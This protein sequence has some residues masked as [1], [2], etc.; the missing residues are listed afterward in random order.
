MEFDLEAPRL[1]DENDLLLLDAEPF[2]PMAP[3]PS[4]RA[5]PL[6]STSESSEIAEA[7]LQRRH[8]ATKQL[9]VD[10]RQEL[11]NSDLAQWKDA[12]AQ[13]M[14]EASGIK[15][16]HK[17]PFIAKKNAAF[18]VM[19][20][21]IGSVG[22]GLGSS[23]MKSPL[24]MF[25][26]NNIMEALTGIQVSTA[27]RKRDR[28]EEDDNESDSEARRLR[29]RKDDG[30]HIGRG[31]DL[32]LNDDDTAMIPGSEVSVNKSIHP[33]LSYVFQGI[34][35]GRHAQITLEDP[36]FPWNVS[37][38]AIG[39][40]QG[41][42]ARGRGFTGSVGGF[43]TSAAGASSLPGMGGMQPSSL[44]RRASRITSA[45][46]L[47]GRSRERYSSLELPT[48]EDDDEL[49]GGQIITDDQALDNFQLYGPAA[50]VDT[51]TAAQSQWVKATLD[52]EAN[53]FLEFVKAEIEAIPSPADDD[54]DELSGEVLSKRSVFFET[55]LPPTQHTKIVAAQALHH[56]LALASRD[57]I[58][59]SQAV[60]WGPIDLA[61]PAGI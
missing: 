34:E 10:V 3:G 23:Q 44:D 33:S 17:A 9:P 29:M 38:S 46:P 28:I 41:S 47:V 37:A 57:L 48:H 43:P 27:G 21:G 15:I 12:Y 13:N 53:N 11:R 31:D 42:L 35:M 19:G 14:S 24:V 22:E 2:P 50:K 20:S 59:V 36:S 52:Q 5:G 16:N 6:R 4:P 60:A 30:E 55:L 49:L 56:V 26:G 61:L 32:I 18:W 39:S 58:N 54:K 40:R 1:D 8:R 45:S 51:Q 7:P 25:S